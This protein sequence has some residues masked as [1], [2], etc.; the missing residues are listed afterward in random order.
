MVGS[1]VGSMSESGSESNFVV[2]L[3]STLSVGYGLRVQEYS[4]SAHSLTEEFVMPTIL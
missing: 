2:G 1:S 4:N 3:G